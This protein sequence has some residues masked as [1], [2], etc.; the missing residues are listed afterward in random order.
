MKNHLTDN[1]D[2]ENIEKN[3]NESTE[4]NGSMNDNAAVYESEGRKD[5]IAMPVNES[6]NNTASSEDDSIARNPISEVVDENEANPV[7]RENVLLILACLMLGILADYLFYGKKFGI[8]YPLFI[9]ALY[10]VF[11]WRYHNISPF[12]F[13]FKWMLSIPIILLS[14]TYCIFDN[15]I[16]KVLNFIGIPILIIAQTILIAKG[17]K[18]KWYEY[19]FVGEI[20]HGMFYRTL[21]YIMKPFRLLLKL[22]EKKSG[23]GIYKPVI[24]VLIA[25]VIS[26]PLVIIIVALL[27]SADQV[28]SGL[29]SKIPDFL[30]NINIYNIIFRIL[31][32]LFLSV[33]FFSYIWS[34]AYAKE[35]KDNIASEDKISSGKVWDPVISATVLMI[36]NLIYIIFIFIQFK[37]LF[38][39]TVPEGLSYSGYARKGF[40]ELVAVTLINLGILLFDINFGKTQGNALNKVIKVLHS[41]LIACTL[42]MLISAFYRMVLYEM[43]YGYTYLRVLTQAFMLFIFALLIATA[44][45]VW[46][47][48]IRLLKA[49]IIIALISYT[50]INYADIDVL[51]AKAN[52]EAGKIDVYYLTQLSH[53]AV[54]YIEELLDYDEEEIVSNVRSNFEFIKKSL[55]NS[56]NW[57][58]FNIARY[59]AWKVVSK[60]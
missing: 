45:K 5:Y 47:Q 56:R 46:N 10:S 16:F 37:Y 26:V 57:Q 25:L 33:V 21:A 32:I 36:I 39:G 7:N 34:F 30:K 50:L 59:R 18:N 27:A 58:S 11:L 38:A 31:I 29:V 23:R 3:D 15:S 51:I 53:D 1:E 40:F 20:L 28:F 2:F 43:K 14:A 4:L 6:A 12:D 52:I 49:Y 55:E 22:I 17:N 41:F 9:I 13:S 35:N 42:I 44:F 60:Y 19:K 8:S 48:K 54:P 24:S